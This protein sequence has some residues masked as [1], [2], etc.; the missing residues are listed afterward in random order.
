MQ[1]NIL[2]YGLLS[3]KT[4]TQCKKSVITTAIFRCRQLRIPST[5]SEVKASV[6]EHCNVLQSTMANMQYF[7]TV[8]SNHSF[9]YTI[10][11]LKNKQTKTYIRT[12]KISLRT[13]YNHLTYLTL[14]VG[15][16]VS[17]VKNNQ[18]TRQFFGVNHNRFANVN[19]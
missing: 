1:K 11:N 8:L 13:G 9:P 10:Q 19:N 14:Q 3:I 12:H 18:M 4:K 5:V 6:P 17:Q 2:L 7:S 15:N 16:Y